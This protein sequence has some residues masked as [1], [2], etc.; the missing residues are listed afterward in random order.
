VSCVIVLIFSC[1]LNFSHVTGL[2]KEDIFPNRVATYTIFL[3]L[4]WLWLY[5]V[6]MGDSVSS[7]VLFFFSFLFFLFFFPRIF[8]CVVDFGLFC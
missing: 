4:L 3:G 5:R 8:V 2:E 1:F 6:G 7:V